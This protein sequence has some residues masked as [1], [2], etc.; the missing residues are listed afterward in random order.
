MS[1]P[2]AEV[3]T[4]KKFEKLLSENWSQRL[5]IAEIN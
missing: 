5:H 4:L 3:P 1:D 2:F